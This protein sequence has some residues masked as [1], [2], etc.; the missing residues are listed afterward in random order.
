MTIINDQIPSL[1]PYFV[2]LFSAAVSQKFTD[3]PFKPLSLHI[4]DRHT[5]SVDPVAVFM[6]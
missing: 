4:T 1:T 2:T 5:T 6:V 3:S